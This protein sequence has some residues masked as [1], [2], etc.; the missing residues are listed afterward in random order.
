MNSS[1]HSM[2]PSMTM[3]VRWSARILSALLLLFWSFFIIGHL[4]GDEGRSSRLLTPNDY[5]S[6]MTMI[7][8]LIGLAV[9]WKWELTGAAMTLVA[10]LT[11]AFINWRVFVFPG[12][13]VP[14]VA[15]LYLLCWWMSRARN[16]QPREPTETG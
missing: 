8:S 4:T 14:I 6:L 12:T 5:I 16:D 2:L 11:G 1:T 13:L 3:L 9:A 15:C 7:I 10:V